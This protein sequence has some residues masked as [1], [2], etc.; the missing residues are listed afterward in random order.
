MAVIDV[1]IV[2]TNRPIMATIERLINREGIWVATTAFS[3]D[4]A[5]ACFLA[6]DFKLIL[7]CAGLDD[8]LVLQEKLR[9]LQPKIPVV[10]H[11]GGGSGLLFAEIHEAL[12]KR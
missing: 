2:G 1:L 8:E 4:E 12:R 10:K 5:V 3:T 6:K 7:L 11:Y 9:Q